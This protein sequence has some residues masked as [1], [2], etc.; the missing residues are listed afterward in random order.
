MGGQEILEE[1]P[2]SDP[3]EIR[4]KTALWKKATY[5]LLITVAL[6]ILLEGVLRIMGYGN[7]EVYIPDERLIWRL[8]PSQETYTK[9]DR[10][11]VY[12]NT[13]GFRNAEFNIKKPKETFRIVA[14][15]DSC[16]Y[17][18]G[19]GQ[20]ETY[21]KILE[22]MLNEGN[23]SG[24]NYEVI[25]CGVIGYSIAQQKAFLQRT[26]LS[27]EPDL[28]LISHTYNEGNRVG[29]SSPPELKS[30][31]FARIRVK[32]ILRNFAIYHFI[33]EIKFRKQYERLMWKATED[34]SKAGRAAIARFETDVQEIIDLCR[35]EKVA[36]A[37]LITMSK[38]Q[39]QSE[40][41]RYSES[42]KSL[43]DIS[44]KNNVPVIVMYEAFHRNKSEELFLAN[45]NIHPS[46]RGQEITALSIY[47]HLFEE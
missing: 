19:V 4:G 30:K 38:R 5:V 31:V 42:Q 1:Q 22:G 2:D 23:Q 10:K 45:D 43:Y 44:N 41:I 34:S 29:P 9:I 15:G 36:L 11:P 32:N 14:C 20:D 25:N 24:K 16:T 33:F 7:V 21:P 35:K 40:R 28:V 47:R 37:F 27:F 6:V 39:T 13:L 17:G 8:R 3:T 26:A 46:A 18:W 12:I